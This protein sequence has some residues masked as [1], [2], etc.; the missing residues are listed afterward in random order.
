M[1][2]IVF[3]ILTLSIAIILASSYFPIKNKNLKSGT[4]KINGVVFDGPGDPPITE[5]MVQDIKK[6]NAEW[7]AV[8]PEAITYVNTLNVKSFLNKGQWYGE[9]MEG[10][11]ITI[12]HAKKNNLKVM[13]KPHIQLS[14]DLSGWEEPEDIDFQNKEDIKKYLESRAAYISTQKKLTKGG[15]R[16]FEPINEED[17]NTW[18]KEYEKFILECAKIA[19]ANAVELFCI[20]TKL[21]KSAVKRSDFWKSLIK[22]VKKIYD[23]PLTYGA[24]WDNYKNI[25]FWNELDYIG[26]SAYFPITRGNS[27]TFEAILKGWKSHHNEIKNISIKFDKP[28]LFTEYGY[29]SVA[30]AGIKPWENNAQND[31]VDF[32]NQNLLYKGIYQTFWNEL[33]FQ[34]GFIWKWYHSGNG[35]KHSYSPQ[36]K[37]A[38][39][40]I[41]KQ[42]ASD[43]Q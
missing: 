14:H 18:E 39:E 35:G 28:V 27:P 13:M 40:T 34:G 38:L 33:W 22:K 1:K 30:A 3:L 32:E 6:S 2:K 43:S 10:A 7:V 15:G 5:K 31:K 42:Y 37:K 41:K 8:I 21:S 11:L 4:P 20:G 29:R 26:I 16:A 9:S 25:S 24:N 23:G 36:E 17:W 12:K 19:D